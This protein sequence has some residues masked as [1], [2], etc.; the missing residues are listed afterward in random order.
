MGWAR[1][2]RTQD[3]PAG[4]RPG[5]RSRQVQ[6]AW[7]IGMNPLGP[8]SLAVNLCHQQVP[9][10]GLTTLC[11]SV[12]ISLS[13]DNNPPARQMCKTQSWSGKGLSHLIRPRVPAG[14][15]WRLS[16]W[17]A[18]RPPG[19]LAQMPGQLWRTHEPC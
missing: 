8:D 1:Q 15:P 11:L 17:V 12:L 13:R 10:V 16:P 4:W 6:G 7:I 9:Q 3:G 2:G 14:S 5:M 19:G 18:Q